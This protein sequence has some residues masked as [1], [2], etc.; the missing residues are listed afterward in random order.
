VGDELA[1]KT[2][3]KFGIDFFAGKMRYE[4]ILP[5]V[6]KR[7]KGS[8]I[9]ITSEMVVESTQNADADNRRILSFR[10]G[11]KLYAI[12][13][14][15]LKEIS[16]AFMPTQ[17]PGLPKCASQMIGFRGHPIPVLDLRILNGEAN[18]QNPAQQIV[19]KFG[20]FPCALWVDE[21]LNVRRAHK[22]DK[23]SGIVKNSSSG[24]L[25]SIVG[26]IIWDGKEA[27]ALISDY[28]VEKLLKYVKE[29]T[30]SLDDCDKKQAA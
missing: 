24:S 27:V 7:Q 2:A 20:D 12:D 30:E 16:S 21:V 8:E 18:P 19:S 3:T 23:A 9:G 29:K 5:Y 25:A 4:D 22:M 28:R 11:T 1:K 26:D 10:V 14:S 6:Q 13:I 15:N 17:L